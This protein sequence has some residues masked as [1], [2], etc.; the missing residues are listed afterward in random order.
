MSEYVDTLNWPEC[1]ALMARLQ[2][3]MDSLPKQGLPLTL[4]CNAVR[5][6]SL[7]IR[8]GG[9]GLDFSTKSSVGDAD[10]VCIKREYVLILR[11]TLSR[12]LEDAT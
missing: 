6:D 8:S 9:D 2:K 4:S 12:W 3:R 10:Y 1:E 11:D 7:T 5:G